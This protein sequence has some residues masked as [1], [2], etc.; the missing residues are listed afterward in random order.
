MN[1]KVAILGGGHG[2]HAM[3]ADLV[4]RGFHTNMYEMPE[5]AANL[6]ELFETKVIHCKGEIEG[7]FE[8]EKVT[9]DIDEAIEGVRYIILVAPAFAHRPYAELLK[10]KV[11][12]NQIILIYPGAFASLI[13]KSTFGD[14]VCPVIA[15]V[16]NLPYD[17]R[18]TAP[19]EVT[20]FGFNRVNI[21]FMPAEKGPELIDEV[22]KLQ[23]FDKV[24][25]DILEAGLSIVNPAIHTGPCLFSI[26]SIENSGKRPFY[27]YEHGVTPASCKLNLSIDQE[28]KKIGEA[29]GYTLT[30][31]EDFSGM[32]EGYT[33]QELYMSIHGN[34]SLTPISGPHEVTSRYLTEDAPYGLVP[35]SQ[36]AKAI[37]VETPVID[38]VINIYGV[39]H[40]KNWWAKGR[41]VEAM[42][43]ENMTPKS[44]KAYVRS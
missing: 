32:N 24:Y 2:A 30:P 36:I 9:S 20:I 28:R 21:A 1:N 22:S 42:G 33:W 43:L 5:F 34:I 31:V 27:L 38:S 8:L 41:N 19:C 7:R 15:E 40:D 3:A 35:W 29:L 12:S 11:T 13:F 26:S 39:V 10:G 44:M 6:S 14:L 23:A 18:L 17:A 4:S 16:N 37:G 25:E